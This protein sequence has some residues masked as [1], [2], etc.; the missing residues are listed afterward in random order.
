MGRTGVGAGA[1]SSTLRQV[2]WLGPSLPGPRDRSATVQVCFVTKNLFRKQNQ[3]CKWNRKEGWGLPPT[4]SLTFIL[5]KGSQRKGQGPYTPKPSL[6]SP[7]P[8]NHW[9]WLSCSPSFWRSPG[10]CL[11]PTVWAGCGV[12]QGPPSLVPLRRTP[13]FA[14]KPCLPL[15]PPPALTL[16]WENTVPAGSLRQET[17]H[18]CQLEATQSSKHSQRAPVPSRAELPTGC[19]PQVRPRSSW[20]LACPTLRLASAFLRA[21]GPGKGG[22]GQE[23]DIRFL[24]PVPQKSQRSSTARD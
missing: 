14:S 6:L 19:T 11:A 21:Q 12:S 22:Q 20:A 3:G 2:Q 1:R 17:E 10:H 23:S 9:L 5:E 8:S 7:V 13:C 24:P 16:A 15:R 18:R 4:Q